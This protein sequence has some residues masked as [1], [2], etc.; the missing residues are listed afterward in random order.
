MRHL[1]ILFIVFLTLNSNAYALSEDKKK[2]VFEKLYQ[3]YSEC[4]VY[5]MFLHRAVKNKESHSELEKD[6]LI[7]MD[8]LRKEAEVNLYFFVDKLNISNDEMNQNLKKIYTSYFDITGRNYS[9]TKSLIDIY[10]EPCDLSLKDPKARMVYWDN[11]FEKENKSKQS[12]KNKTQ[13]ALINKTFLCREI[14]SDYVVAYEIINDSDALSYNIKDWKVK[15][16]KRNYKIDIEKITFTEFNGT[17]EWASIDRST[18]KLNY[19]NQC[20]IIDKPGREIIS[21]ILKER[22]ENR[23][24]NNKF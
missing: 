12:L 7:K 14:G 11:V 19:K 6:F 15:E 16:Y 10:T 3:E 17:I 9:N 1:I 21:N 13:K 4:T 23:K 24:K 5:Y 2:F 22:I 20:E 18:L 8:K